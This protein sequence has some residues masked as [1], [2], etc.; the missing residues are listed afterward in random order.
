MAVLSRSGR[1]IGTQAVMVVTGLVVGFIV[2]AIVLILIGANQSNMLVDFV[3]DI[4]RWLTTP[5]HELFIRPT[6]KQ[7]VLIN[8]GIAVIAYAAVGALLARLVRE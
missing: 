6:Q 7:N 4:A 5:F 1:E 3:V 2:L 8:W